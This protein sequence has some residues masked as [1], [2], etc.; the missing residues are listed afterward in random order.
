MQR[1][2]GTRVWARLL[3]ADSGRLDVVVRSSDVVR[4]SVHGA[5]P[6]AAEAWWNGREGQ[7]GGWRGEREGR[8][9]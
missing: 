1:V 9:V 2:R 8:N 3:G 7:V 4:S 5:A 6:L